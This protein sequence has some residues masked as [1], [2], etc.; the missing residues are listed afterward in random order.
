M[1]FGL[2]T[3]RRFILS[4]TSADRFI[5]PETV[6]TSSRATAIIQRFDPHLVRISSSWRLAAPLLSLTLFSSCKCKETPPEGSSQIQSEPA[7]VQ[8]GW[9]GPWNLRSEGDMVVIDAGGDPSLGS[10][11]FIGNQHHM[12][13]LEI[14]DPKEFERVINHQI[15]I[16]R[17]LERTRPSI[18]FVEALTTNITS[19]ALRSG[20]IPEEFFQN[21]DYSSKDRDIFGQG[22]ELFKNGI[23]RELT[24]EQRRWVGIVGADYAYG[25]SQDDVL[26]HR[27]NTPQEYREIMKVFDALEKQRGDEQYTET[28]REIDRVREGYLVREVKTFMT[29]HRPVSVVVPFG[30][31]HMTETGLGAALRKANFAPHA[32]IVL[33]GA[34]P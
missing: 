30:Q 6:E 29:E 1:S 31:F 21:Q 13:G 24:P 2:N 27:T 15:R 34:S 5:V 22:R 8:T 25:F 9:R 4:F 19:N 11:L 32:Q 33:F 10:A 7:P 23:P 16:L 18:I 14:H 3:L 20:K 26:L 28:D 17:L 12:Q